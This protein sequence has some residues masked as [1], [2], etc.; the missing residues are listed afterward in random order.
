MARILYGPGSMLRL[1]DIHPFWIFM[2]ND[3]HFKADAVT[4]S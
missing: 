3:T 2:T 4:N 1:M